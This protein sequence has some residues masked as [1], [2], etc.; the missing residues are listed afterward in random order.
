MLGKIEGKEEKWVTEDEML[1]W[2]K[3]N[4]YEFEQTPRDS[5]GQG[6]LVCCKPWDCKELDMTEQLNNNPRFRTTEVCIKRSIPGSP[7]VGEVLRS[8]PW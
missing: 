8:Q 2:L 7:G 3:L 6:R 1:G 5:E 4:G